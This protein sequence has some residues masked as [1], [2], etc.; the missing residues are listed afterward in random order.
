MEHSK[1]SE[2]KQPTKRKP[3]KK[4]KQKKPEENENRKPSHDYS[5]LAA[6]D[7]RVLNMLEISPATIDEISAANGWSFAETIDE[8]S[9]LTDLGYVSETAGA[10]YIIKNSK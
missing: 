5:L 6:D 1:V 10:Q 4:E 8:M 9:R 3:V 2:K 7:I